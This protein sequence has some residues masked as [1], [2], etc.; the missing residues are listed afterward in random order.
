MAIR[1]IGKKIKPQTL[2]I[3]ETTVPPGT[4]EKVV[5]PIIS[6]EFQRRNI[7]SKNILIA[8]SYERVMPGAEYFDSIVN[9]WRVY[10]GISEEAKKICGEF[11][12][13]IINVEKYPLTCLESTTASETAKVLEN[14]YR[15]ANI[16]FITEWGEFAEKVGIDLFEVISAIRKR[17]THSNMRQP[18]FGVG[19]YCLTKDAYFA[20]LAAKELFNVDIPFLFSTKAVEVNNNMPITIIN[21]IKEYFNYDLRNVKILLLGVSYRED[22]ADTRYSPSETFVKEALINGG[23]I[24]CNDPLVNWWEE[25]HMEVMNEVPR[26]S[27][28]DVVVFAVNHKV[29]KKINLSDFMGNSNTLLF[30]ANNVLTE[31]QL[32]QIKEKKYNFLAVGRGGI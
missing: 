28:F 27:D 17:P 9:Y 16:A 15:A 25:M 30:D 10:S 31:E 23:H 14:S 5:L 8:H 21:K 13:S 11:L 3:V 22:V 7:S 26:F 4:C 20:P 29:Y 6:E 19:G 2:I 18:G 1:T 12:E 24:V 32:L